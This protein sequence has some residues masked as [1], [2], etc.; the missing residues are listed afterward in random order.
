MVRPAAD[1]YFSLS[2]TAGHPEAD[3]EE[4]IAPAGTDTADPHRASGSPACASSQVALEPEANRS[5]RETRPTSTR[6]STDLDAE[7]DRSRRQ[8]EEATASPR[9]RTRTG[10]SSASATTRSAHL[11]GSR[12]PIE[13]SP[14]ISAPWQDAA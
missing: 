13:R 4:L 2:D 9:R 7:Y 1:R 5:R 14:R 8:R 12:A 10:A 6:N 3:F 11:P